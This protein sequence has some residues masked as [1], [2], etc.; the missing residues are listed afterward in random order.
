MCREMNYVTYLVLHGMVQEH[1]KGTRNTH[2]ASGKLKPLVEETLSVALEARPSPWGVSSWQGTSLPARPS[3]GFAGVGPQWP[4]HP[5]PFAPRPCHPVVPRPTAYPLGFPSGKISDSPLG[6]FSTRPA[7]LESVLGLQRFPQLPSPERKVSGIY[8]SWL[9]AHQVRYWI[10]FECPFTS[11]IIFVLGRN[12]EAPQKLHSWSSL[13]DSI[14]MAH[15]Q[16][17]VLFH[18]KTPRFII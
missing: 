1:F 8:N 6:S 17:S 14:T 4:Q 11:C 16:A 5:R 7:R 2:G 18:D 9:V 3:S 15:F 10:V 12:E 13:L